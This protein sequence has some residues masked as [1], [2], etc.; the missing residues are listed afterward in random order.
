M[1]IGPG[2]SLAYDGTPLGNAFKI[3][4]AAE[5]RGFFVREE[6]DQLPVLINGDDIL[7]PASKQLYSAWLNEVNKLG[8]KPSV[9]KNYFSDQ[10]FTVNSEL[11]YNDMTFRSR[12]WWGGFETDLVRLRN[13]LKFETG[14]DVLSADL[15]RVFPKMQ[16]FLRETCDDASWPI[17]N[18][19]WL[20][21]Y[22]DM[23]ILSAY[24]G[25]NWFIP[26]E[27]GG[28]GLDSTG[29]GDYKI[30]FAQR[31][32]A[33]RLSL[34]PEGARKFFPGA[35]GS[36]TTEVSQKSLRESRPT[37]CMHGEIVTWKGYRYILDRDQ[38]VRIFLAN[39]RMQ[40]ALRAHPTLD[41]FV[42]QS[43]HIDN[44]LDFHMR[45]VRYDRE[46]VVQGIRRALLWGLRISDRHLTDVKDIDLKPRYV[47]LR[48]TH[49]IPL[50]YL[51][52]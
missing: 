21:H 26:V 24:S 11:Y 18:R 30:T 51:Q 39:G 48:S 42:G 3:L 22:A 1:F 10:F 23:G 31:K 29:W 5:A 41:T 12:P 16:T 9:G 8:L 46:R 44:W 40:L 45:G 27:L 2:L 7:F 37:A 52:S 6:L 19:L 15:R 35:E 32:L 28:L 38:P 43:S 49:F 33:V 20:K 47:C 50:V 36:L 13:E 25:L 4:K 14:E 34:D 17:I